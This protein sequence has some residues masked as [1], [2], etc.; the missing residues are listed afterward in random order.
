MSACLLRHLIQPITLQRL[1]LKY[2]TKLMRIACGIAQWHASA[3]ARSSTKN[4]IPKNQQPIGAIH[5]QSNIINTQSSLAPLEIAPRR[6]LDV[7]HHPG[8]D[9]RCQVTNKL[10]RRLGSVGRKTTCHRTINLH[11]SLGASSTFVIVAD[12]TSVRTSH[13]N[14]V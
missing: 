12:Y 5:F 7:A 11:T 6:S 4:N 14:F 8:V 3:D 10:Y 2:L 13:R 9:S 1:Y